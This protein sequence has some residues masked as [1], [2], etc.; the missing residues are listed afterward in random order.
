MFGF[1]AYYVGKKLCICLYEQGVGIKVPAE[2]A[3]RLLESDP[4]VTPFMP[5]GK[6]KMREWIQIN[7]ARSEEYGQYMP[8]FAESIDYVLSQQPNVGAKE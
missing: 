3:A 5:L 1:P 7:L 4:N 8:V 2:T 6:P